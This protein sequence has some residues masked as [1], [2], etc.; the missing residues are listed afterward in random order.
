[1]VDMRIELMEKNYSMI[2]KRLKEEI[3]NSLRSKK[4]VILFINKRGHT[5]FIFAENADIF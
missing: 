5:S 4:Q 3:E 1:M 2:S